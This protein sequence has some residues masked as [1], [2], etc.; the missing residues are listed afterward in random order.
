MSLADEIDD[1]AADGS[2]S[3]DSESK[4][5]DGR[6][7]KK[8]PRK[9]TDEFFNKPENVEWKTKSFNAKGGR[10]VSL[11]LKHFVWNGLSP[12]QR[13]EWL[14]DATFDS[15]KF[16]RLLHGV[17]HRARE[18]VVESKSNSAAVGEYNS[19]NYACPDAKRKNAENQAIRRTRP[20]VK[21]KQKILNQNYY[22][23]NKDC[24]EYK[25]KKKEATRRRRERHYGKFYTLYPFL[26]NLSNTLVL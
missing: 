19:T 25:K 11:R 6:K 14:G 12:Q 23:A 10:I 4:K 16:S 2:G 7:Q 20:E 15:P 24:P 1:D 5:P 26:V 21:K 18:R 22:Q 8:P 9:L 3:D 13:T 17:V